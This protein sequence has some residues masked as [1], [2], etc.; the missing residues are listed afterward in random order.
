ML[1]SC[2][3]NETQ[4]QN[5]VDAARNLNGSKTTPEYCAAYLVKTGEHPEGEKRGGL[6]QVFISSTT[7]CRVFYDETACE[8]FPYDTCPS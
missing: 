1:T 5:A 4:H 6:V 3:E 7:P 2:Y 8:W